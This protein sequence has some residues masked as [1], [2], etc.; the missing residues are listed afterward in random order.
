MATSTGSSCIPYAHQSV[1]NR[2]SGDAANTA[3]AGTM[4]Q[5]APKHRTST[6]Q[7]NH[8]AT[9]CMARSGRVATT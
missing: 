2:I 4:P 1:G 5:R 3:N 6:R 8:S 9:P 7:N